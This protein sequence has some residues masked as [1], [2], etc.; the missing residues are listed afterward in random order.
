MATAKRFRYEGV[1]RKRNEPLHE[2][3]VVHDNTEATP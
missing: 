3:R 2:T 1:I